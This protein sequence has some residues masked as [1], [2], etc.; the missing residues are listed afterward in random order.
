[1]DNLN[2]Y[3]DED[4]DHLKLYWPI[5]VAGLIFIVVGILAYNIGADAL[6]SSSAKVESK[7][8]LIVGF[9]VYV[10]VIVSFIGVIFQNRY[11]INI[12]VLA[13]NRQE[14]INTLREQ[15]VYF[16]SSV[17]SIIRS[18]K[19]NYMSGDK[20]VMAFI[21]EK[22]GD[23]SNSYYHIRLLLSSTQ[24]KKDSLGRK[25]SEDLVKKLTSLKKDID[26][27]T[28]LSFDQYRDVSKKIE[29][30]K[31]EICDTAEKIL[32]AEWVRVKR[33]V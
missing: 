25:N 22:R 7:I 23:L 27:Y 29:Q 9:L 4:C 17:E 13:K 15:V 8:T 3:Q 16:N 1:M 11:R 20:E 19:D 5:Y 24:Q 6:S 30:N 18:L 26:S 32:K 31:K 28:A 33:G 10:G 2:S 21:E 12:E 14:W